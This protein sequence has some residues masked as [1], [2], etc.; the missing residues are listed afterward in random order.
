MPNRIRD[1][2]NSLIDETP[3]PAKLHQPTPTFN[4]DVVSRHAAAKI[5]SMPRRGDES[6][7]IARKRAAARVD[8]TGSY[9]D[10]RREIVRAAAQVFKERGFRGTTLTHVAEAMNAD[11]ASLYYYV[12]SKED[13]FQEIV[14]DAV[15]VNLATASAIRD[16]DWPAPEKLRRLLEGLMASYAEYYPFLYVLI[17]ENLT[18]V[19]PERS[20]W[21]D[22][23]KRVNREY[24]QI[25]IDIVQTGQDEGTLRAT[26]PAWLL[27]YGIIGM[28]GWTNRWFNPQESTVTA[29]E[30]GSVFADTLLAG[31]EDARPAKPKR[32]SRAR[33]SK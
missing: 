27:A 11:R 25:L 16:E 21:A 31:L 4:N 26:A 8:G 19:A 6:S 29:E 7:K 15:H 28:V 23:M 14:S 18:H 9:A 12:S 33:T 30:I 2:P 13:V 17:Q 22:E 24:E 1:T 32:R 20:E 3:S 10:R 5:A